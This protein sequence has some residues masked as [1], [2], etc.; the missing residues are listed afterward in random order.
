M[1]TGAYGNTAA[2][3]Q[4]ISR[5]ITKAGGCLLPV[6][7]SWQLALQTQLLSCTCTIG[8]VWEPSCSVDSESP[9]LLCLRCSCPLKLHSCMHNP[10]V[11]CAD[12][13]GIDIAVCP[14]SHVA[15]M[16]CC[17]SECATLCQLKVSASCAG[18][19][20]ETLNLEN[21]ELADVV[22][23]LKRCKGFVIGSPTLGGHMPTQVCFVV[24]LLWLLPACTCMWPRLSALKGC[25]GSSL[26]H[27]RW[28]AAS[29]LR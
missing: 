26:A 13:A 10:R 3:A 2:L 9:R 25:K 8:L 7:L 21:E 20:V 6:Q 24:A 27:P 23:A 5:G 29:P 4:A 1:C 17:S 11:F 28:A 15:S 16:L 19:G 18:V 14:A 12:N 22:S